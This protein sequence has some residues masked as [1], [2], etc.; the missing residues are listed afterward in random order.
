MFQEKFSSELMQVKKTVIQAILQSRQKQQQ[1]QKNTADRK[2]KSH[3]QLRLN[4]Q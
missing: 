1:Q 4:S 3:Y 2:V